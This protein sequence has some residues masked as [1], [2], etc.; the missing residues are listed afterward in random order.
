MSP[1]RN[2]ELPVHSNFKLHKGGSDLKIFRSAT[3][4]GLVSR[5]RDA[6]VTIQGGGGRRASIGDTVPLGD[7]VVNGLQSPS[8]QRQNGCSGSHRRVTVRVSHRRLY[9]GTNT[10]LLLVKYANAIK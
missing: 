1:E 4:N 2:T 8:Y 5:E 3:E 7:N 6:R 9:T 10:I